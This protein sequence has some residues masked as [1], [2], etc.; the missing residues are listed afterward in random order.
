MCLRAKEAKD[1]VVPAADEGGNVT[2]F[3][4]KFHP[5]VRALLQHI[6]ETRKFPYLTVSGLLR[7]A[8]VEHLENLREL[9]ELPL[10]EVHMLKMIIGKTRR[11]QFDKQYE[12]VV[13]GTA[14]EVAELVAAG[15][16]KQA[17]KLALEIKEQIKGLPDNDM[18]VDLTAEITRR[19]GT[20]IEDL[21]VAEL[22]VDNE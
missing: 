6:I 8:L 15:K 2:T 10:T 7:H 4:F 11:R 12:E 17:A 1:F 9:G 14:K 19:W 21:A 16:R 13:V 18:K 5:G 3:N 20:L 22:E